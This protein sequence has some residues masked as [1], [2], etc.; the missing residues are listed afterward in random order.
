MDT[1]LYDFRQHLDSIEWIYS[2][3]NGLVSE[4][5]DIRYSVVTITELEDGYE[6]YIGP[7][8]MELG[9]DAIQ[10]ILSDDFQLKDYLIERIEPS[11]Y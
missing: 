2:L 11:P 9:G 1:E 10:V 6:I 4:K 3:P 7:K 8:E 5:I